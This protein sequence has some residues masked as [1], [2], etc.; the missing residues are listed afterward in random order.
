MFV[1]E[2]PFMNLEQI[3]N[4]RQVPRW[5]KL[6]DDKFIVIHKDKALKIEQKKERFIMNCSEDEFFDIWFKYFDLQTDYMTLNRKVKRL[7]GKFKIV[8]NRGQGI[9]I[10][11]QD[12][13]ES[14]VYSKIIAN[15][16]YDKAWI[17]MNHIAMVCGTKH[18]QAMREAGK[19]TWYEFPTP[20]MILENF[21]NLGKMGKINNWLKRLCEAI[22][23]D[24][25]AYTKCG[26]ELYQLFAANDKSEFPTN[27]IEELLAKNFDCDVEDFADMY[28]NEVENKGIAYMYI[29]HHKLNPPKEMMRYGTY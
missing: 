28:L 3:Y 21:D 18:V 15:V 11:N 9:H 13:F 22:V 7:G 1:I 12:E 4:S 23:N 8:A 19:I 5:I 6:R 29:L 26:N 25:Y 16:G 20:E 10:L 24:Y 27:G 17:A 14:Y 2:I